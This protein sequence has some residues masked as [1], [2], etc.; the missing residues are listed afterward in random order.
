MIENAVA[1]SEEL[2]RSAYAVLFR[3]KPGRLNEAGKVV[4]DQVL[5]GAAKQTTVNISVT[6]HVDRSGS[7]DSYLALSLRRADAVREVLISGGI[8]VPEQVNR[9]S[10]IIIE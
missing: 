9:A 1:R 7:E 8:E 3:V 6:G 10:K 2:R 4:V 5:A